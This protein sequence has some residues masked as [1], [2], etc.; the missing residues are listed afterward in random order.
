M[1]FFK[2]N[3]NFENSSKFRRN[4]FQVDYYIQN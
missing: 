4:I 3:N 2:K 1:V